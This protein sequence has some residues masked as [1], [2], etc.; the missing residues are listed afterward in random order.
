MRQ[1]KIV[2]QNGNV[3]QVIGKLADLKK[4]AGIDPKKTVVVKQLIKKIQKQL[5]EQ[6]LKLEW[7]EQK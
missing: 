6:N 1:Y 5:N 3:V 2:D 4:Y 7:E